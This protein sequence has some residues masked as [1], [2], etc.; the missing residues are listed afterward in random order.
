MKKIQSSSPV[1]QHSITPVSIDIGLRYKSF[2]QLKG[3]TIDTNEF[4]CGL[5]YNDSTWE[6]GS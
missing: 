2:G 5:K 4:I 3:F 1:L 6:E